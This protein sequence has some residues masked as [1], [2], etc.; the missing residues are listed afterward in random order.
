MGLSASN[1]MGNLEHKGNSLADCHT[2][3]STLVETAD[4]REQVAAQPRE[5]ADSK[6]EDRNKHNKGA[7]DS[8]VR[9]NSRAMAQT[10]CPG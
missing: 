5:Q 10:R 1:S 2:K 9:D 3:T 6:E 4:R 8:R 7:P